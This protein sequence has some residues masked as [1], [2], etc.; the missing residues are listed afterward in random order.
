MKKCKYIVCNAINVAAVERDVAIGSLDAQDA[1]A[2]VEAM[3]GSYADRPMA[4]PNP[5]YGSDFTADVRSPYLTL[6]I[7]SRSY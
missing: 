1:K 3:F 5:Y 7:T 6:N 2:L 4:G